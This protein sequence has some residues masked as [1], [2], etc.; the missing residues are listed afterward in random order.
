MKAPTRIEAMIKWIGLNQEVLL[1][2][3]FSY[4][5]KLLTKKYR[6]LILYP[7]ICNWTGNLRWQLYLITRATTLPMAH[8]DDTLS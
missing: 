6:F 8:N 3:T 5:I 2:N 7:I 4:L 1:Y